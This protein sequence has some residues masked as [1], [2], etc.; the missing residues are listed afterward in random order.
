MKKKTA[1]DWWVI[2]GVLEMIVG[3]VGVLSRVNTDALAVG[4]VLGAG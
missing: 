2:T 3:I 1:M 4:L